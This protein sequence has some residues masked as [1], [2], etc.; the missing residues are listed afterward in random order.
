MPMNISKEYVYS[1][2]RTFLNSAGVISVCLIHRLTGG[3][4][5]LLKYFIRD[6]FCIA[7]VSD[8]F[9]TSAFIIPGF[10][11][12]MSSKGVFSCLSPCGHPQPGGEV[13]NPGQ[14]RGAVFP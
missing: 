4:S 2:S 12:S 3:F 6:V 14:A 11:L 13:K 5:C 9:A 8:W 10:L 7:R 1:S